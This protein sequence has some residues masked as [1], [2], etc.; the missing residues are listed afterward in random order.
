LL[1][2]NNELDNSTDPTVDLFKLLSFSKS[3]AIGKLASY[4]AAAYSAYKFGK[5]IHTGLIKPPYDIVI[6]DNDENFN[7]VC[8]KILE[9]LPFKDHRSLRAATVKLD[10]QGKQITQYSDNLTIE[11]VDDNAVSK[12]TI[13]FFY[14]GLKPQKITIGG[15]EVTVSYKEV[16]RQFKVSS[17][18]IFSTKKLAGQ[19]AVKDF[20]AQ[21]VNDV[22]KKKTI[23]IF[24]ANQWGEIS[25]QAEITQRPLNT[26]I[27]PSEQKKLL[28]EDIEE[29]LSKKD[30]YKE[31]HLPYHRGYLFYGPP[32]TGKTSLIR[33]IATE[34]NLDLYTFSL[35]NFNNDAQFLEAMGKVQ[36]GSIVAL[37][38]IDVISAAT[39]RTENNKKVTLAG[40]ANGL[41]GLITPEGIIIILSTNKK[42]KLDK[43]ITRTGRT[44]LKLNI[45]YVVEEQ[46]LQIFKAFYPAFNE[47]LNFNVVANATTSD[48]FNICKENFNSPDIARKEIKRLIK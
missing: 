35:A 30:K 39:E 29:F 2:F 41:D 24:T 15:F 10:N 18:L 37:E 23:S 17:S 4:S 12:K 6:E 36:P 13:K 11:G 38:D 27:L 22:Q 20:L 19:K 25:R 7:L 26:I 32:G 16:E 5:A 3:E 48:V 28:T 45:G 44:D 1:D 34:Y 8:D 33:G 14:S 21:I 9:M 46:I 31:M 42:K 43:A 40:L 47:E